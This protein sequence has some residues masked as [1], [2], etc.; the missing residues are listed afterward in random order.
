MIDVTL[1][2]PPEVGA[3]LAEVVRW[4]CGRLGVA[5]ASV[6]LMVVGP[7][8]MARVNG[9]HRGKAEPT[10]VLAFPVDGPEVLDGE[11]PAEGPPPELGDVIICPEAADLPLETLAVHGLLHLLG[12]DH[13]TDAGEMLELQDRLLEE[14]AARGRSRCRG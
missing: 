11:W 4:T 14:W 7:D 8:E 6:G 12:H 1:E 9:E 2:A 10:D 5:R 13:E 3:P